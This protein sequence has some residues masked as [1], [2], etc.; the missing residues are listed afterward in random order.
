MFQGWYI[1]LLKHK[2]KV[3]HSAEDLLYCLVYVI[4]VFRQKVAN[5]LPTLTNQENNT[6]NRFYSFLLFG[7]WVITR[8][9]FHLFCNDTKVY[10]HLNQKEFASFYSLDLLDLVYVREVLL[11]RFA[12]LLVS[13]RQHFWQ[14]V[15]FWIARR[16]VGVP[17]L[18]GLWVRGL[19]VAYWCFF[20]VSSPPCC[21]PI[22][23]LIQSD[24]EPRLEVLLIRRYCLSATIFIDFLLF[25]KALNR[26][27]C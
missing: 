25:D 13:Q 8:W 26:L 12:M 24:M 9:Y 5:V 19:L 17:S 7:V 11:S 3:R 1:W 2:E 22:I 27:S 4:H 23:R 14:L 18:W 10:I 16:L 15:D 20:F 6:K 21:H